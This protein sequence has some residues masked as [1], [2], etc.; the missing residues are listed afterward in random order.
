MNTNKLKQE[1]EDY[2]KT[3]SG[4]YTTIDWWI[5]KCEES[6]QRGLRETAIAVD[7]RSSQWLRSHNQ[8]SKEVLDDYANEKVKQERERI[9]SKLKEY[10]GI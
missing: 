3:D 1:W 7:L 9:L 8:L 2:L 6:Y 5:T 4:T 10:Y